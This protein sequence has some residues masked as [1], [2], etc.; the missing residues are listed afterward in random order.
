MHLCTLQ[1][2]HFSARGEMTSHT[3]FTSKV[4]KTLGEKFKSYMCVMW[5]KRQYLGLCKMNG[6]QLLKFRN[7]HAVRIS[8]VTLRLG[9]E[10]DPCRRDLTNI[11]LSY[12]VSDSFGPVLGARAWSCKTTNDYLSLSQLRR[13][14][15]QVATRTSN[16]LYY[17]PFIWFIGSHYPRSYI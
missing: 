9:S 5:Y 15:S 12:L 8:P 13:E 2:T 3:S 17:F 6:R 10:M 7:G 16:V 11:L 14:M 4:I 1:Q